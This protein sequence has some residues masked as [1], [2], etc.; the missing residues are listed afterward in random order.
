VRSE[1]V[2]LAILKHRLADAVT[3]DEQLT[4]VAELK[5]LLTVQFT[6]SFALTRCTGLVNNQ[7]RY[8]W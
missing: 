2:P 8:L 3:N 7:I 1:D 5:E 6:H 4:L